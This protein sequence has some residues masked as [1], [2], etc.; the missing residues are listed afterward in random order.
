MSP[1][2]K[3][4]TTLIIIL[5]IAVLAIIGCVYVVTVFGNNGNKEDTKDNPQT[6]INTE[7]SASFINKEVIERMGYDGLVSEVASNDI[8]GH[9]DIPEDSITQASIYIANS[10]ESAMEL[11]CFKLKDSENSKQLMEAI[12]SHIATKEKGFQES[13]KER[14]Y[15]KNYVTVNANG[16]LFMAISENPEVAGKVFLE[17][18]ES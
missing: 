14:E 1:V 5:L 15:I 18:F 4:Y 2:T 10:S 13:P 6:N 8:S 9:F 7:L 3:K 12:S 16:Y 17:V 11:A